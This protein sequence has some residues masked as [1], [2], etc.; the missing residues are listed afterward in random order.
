MSL[1]V[2]A[3]A[4]AIAWVVLAALEQVSRLLV[5]SMVMWGS[6]LLGDFLQSQVLLWPFLGPLETG[7]KFYLGEKLRFF[8]SIAYTLNSFGPKYFASR[9]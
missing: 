3:I 7:P 2:F 9:P 1:S 8:I 6:H 4:I 5:A